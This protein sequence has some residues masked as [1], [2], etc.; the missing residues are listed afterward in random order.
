MRALDSYEVRSEVLCQ[1]YPSEPKLF[2]AA[3]QFVSSPSLFLELLEPPIHRCEWK[4]ETLL[5]CK[6]Q[7]GPKPLHQAKREESG[8]DASDDVFLCFPDGIVQ[9]GLKRRLKLRLSN[10]NFEG[11]LL[12]STFLTDNGPLTVPS[13]SFEPLHFQF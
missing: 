2:V 3:T 5:F 13:L 12:L 1:S 9:S 8:R 10:F 6:C 7:I 4:T 11:A